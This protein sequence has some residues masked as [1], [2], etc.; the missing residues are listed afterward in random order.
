MIELY[1]L[2]ADYFQKAVSPLPSLSQ[3]YIACCCIYPLIKAY[4]FWWTSLLC[5]RTRFVF[6]FLAAHLH[7]DRNYLCDRERECIVYIVAFYFGA[8]FN[9][10]PA[11][12]CLCRCNSNSMYDPRGVGVV[13]RSAAKRRREETAATTTKTSQSSV[14]S[15]WKVFC[16]HVRAASLARSLAHSLT[17][18]L[19]SLTLKLSLARRALAQPSLSQLSEALKLLLLWLPVACVDCAVC[20]TCF[21]FVLVA[22]AAARSLPLCVCDNAGHSSDCALPHLPLAQRLWKLNL[23]WVNKC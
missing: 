6:F 17:D 5:S 4:L 12:S 3:P 22:A 19:C 23:N 13:W 21:R 9:W 7:N 2:R 14:A 16:Q 20:V 8:H 1:D 15:Q 11:S 10:A 18:L